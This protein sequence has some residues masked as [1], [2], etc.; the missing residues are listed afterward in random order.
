MDIRLECS[1]KS[2][3]TDVCGLNIK[4][5]EIVV[6]LCVCRVWGCFD[7]KQDSY[8]ACRRLGY[9]PRTQG[10]PLSTTEPFKMLMIQ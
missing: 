6:G 5:S 4:V 7:K 2:L 8:T 9:V 10:K 1:L 3:M